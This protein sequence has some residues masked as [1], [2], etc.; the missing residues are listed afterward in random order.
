VMQDDDGTKSYGEQTPS[1]PS[2]IKE[3]ELDSS[4]STN[5]STDVPKQTTDTQRLVK[6]NSSKSKHKKERLPNS[7]KH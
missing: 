3:R 4:P 2:Y 1:H 6:K 7:T 5:V